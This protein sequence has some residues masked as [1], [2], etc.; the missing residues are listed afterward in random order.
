[1][2]FTVNYVVL[3][4][5]TLV[6]WTMVKRIIRYVKKTTNLGVYY[7]FNVNPCLSVNSDSNYEGD[8]KTRRLT[9]GHL[10]MLRLPTVSW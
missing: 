5:P 1:M 7:K 8:L 4:N 2:A 9:L 10:F 6:H 3:N